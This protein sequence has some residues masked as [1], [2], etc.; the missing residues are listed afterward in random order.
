MYLNLYLWLQNTMLTPVVF[1]GILKLQVPDLWEHLIA[2]G[3]LYC[4]LY[5]GGHTVKA[6]L[7]NR[8]AHNV[9]AEQCNQHRGRIPGPGACSGRN[10]SGD[11]PDQMD[12]GFYRH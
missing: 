4:G 8:A 10:E 2:F 3:A 5:M 7:G 1:N 6:I 11:S 12:E 9:A